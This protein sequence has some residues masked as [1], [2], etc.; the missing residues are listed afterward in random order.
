MKN[1]G[2]IIYLVK[3]DGTIIHKTFCKLDAR[4][5]KAEYNFDLNYPHALAK[6]FKATCK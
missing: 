5:V 4:S 6:M 1:A 2:R 3:V